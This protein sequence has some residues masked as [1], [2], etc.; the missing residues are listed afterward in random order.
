MNFTNA[1]Y[2]RFS[3]STGI[4]LLVCFLFVSVQAQRT[5]RLIDAWQPNH[6]DV[7]VVFDS[8]LSQ[9]TSA[10]TDVTVTVLKNDVTMIDLDF[11]TMPVSAVKVNNQLA[12]F[13][14]HNEKLDVYLTNP[15][16]KNQKL[17]ISV[18]YSGKPQD[19][20][21][22]TKDKDGNPS[23]VGDNW[24][25]R[26]HHWIPC[27]DHPSAK[28]SVRFTVTASSKYAVVANGVLESTKDNPDNTKTLVWYESAKISPYNMVVAVGQFANATLKTKSPV[29]ISYYVTHSDRQFAEQGFS[30]AAPSLQTFSNLINAPYPYQKLALIV[31]ATKFGG[32]E[33]ANT[34]VFAPNLFSNFLEAKPRS[35]RYQIPSGVEVLIAHEIAHQWFGDS[36]TEATWADL[37]LS[38]GF[39]TYFAGLFLEKNESQDAFR[40]YMKNNAETYF[41]F[42]KKRRIPIHDTNT[43]K[44]FDLLNANNYQKGAWVLHNLRGTLGDKDFFEGISIYYNNHQGAT[45]TTEDLRAALEK[46]SGKDLRAFFERWIYKSG[47]PVYQVSWKEAG[48]KTI[49]VTLRQTQ[50]DELFLQPVTLEVITNKEKK[51]IEVTPKDRETSVKVKIANPTGIVIDPDDFILNEVVN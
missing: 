43:P 41:R 48:K 7:A 29:P 31:G 14:Q 32:M 9:I 44:L 19:G 24:A 2:S 50:E 4:C 18:S 38:E 51:R 1:I 22:L 28:A 35:Q 8:E 30:P 39:A 37:W 20:L 6:F 34:I 46:A 12:R 15:A 42:A 36:V 17:N 5:E 49:E 23:A 16:Q 40:A 3:N 45:A 11:G 25:D 27:L 26:V 21:I 13:A 10:T 47:H 33:N